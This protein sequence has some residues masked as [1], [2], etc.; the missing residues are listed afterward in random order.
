MGRYHGKRWEIFF[1]ENRLRLASCFGSRNAFHRTRWAIGN[2]S[3]KIQIAR[4]MN[5]NVPPQKRLRISAIHIRAEARL[6]RL[7]MEKFLAEAD[8]LEAM[9]ADKS[10]DQD[11]LK[12]EADQAK[13]NRLSWMAFP[14]F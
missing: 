8:R 7:K 12:R 9:A 5:N 6:L 14:S 3:E 2:R 4:K 1:Q 10:I 13:N 11:H